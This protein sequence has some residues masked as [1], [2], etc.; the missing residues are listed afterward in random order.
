[1]GLALRVRPYTTIYDMGS[2]IPI[3]NA[4]NTKVI[5]MATPL[6]R[7]E[8]NIGRLLGLSLMLDVE[9]QQPFAD[10]AEFLHG[11]RQHSLLTLLALPLP[12]NTVREH[13]VRIVYNPSESVTK[14]ASFAIGYGFGEKMQNG[15]APSVWTSTNVP[16][17]TAVKS[18][19]KTIVEE[20]LLADKVE[21]MEACEMREVAEI[22]KV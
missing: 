15:A 18:K 19:C 14:A 7:K 1:M 9:T 12:L 16:V 4:A 8:F 10:F 17:P 20:Q 5:R 6:K 3:A 22:E 13:T 2:A 11:L 21:R